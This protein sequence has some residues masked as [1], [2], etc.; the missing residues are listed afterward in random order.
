MS[1]QLA[2][3]D[4][5]VSMIQTVSVAI[6]AGVLLIIVA[7][8]INFPAIVLLLLGGVALGPAVLGEHA[9]VN[10]TA[11]GGGLPVLVSF[12][13]GLILF[14]GGLTLDPEGYRTAPR[15]IKRLLTLGILITWSG[16]STAV[17]LLTDVEPKIAI[18]CGSM[19]IVTGPTVIAPLL[20]RL[21]VN[22][23]L[24]SI[25]HWE[26]VLIDPMG[27]FIAV[28]CFEVVVAGASGQ[29]AA[30]GLGLRIL[31]G[32]G[33]GA[34]GGLALSWCTRRQLIPEDMLNVF[35]VAVAVLTFG[36]A[37]MVRPEAGLLSVTVAGFVFGLTGA[38]RVKQV[39]EFKAELT[40]LLI[41]MLFILLSARLSFDQFSAFGLAGA[42]AVASVMVL[43]RPLAIMACSFGLD[44]TRNERIFLSWVAPRGIVAASLASLF[45]ISIKERYPEIADSA[46]FVETFVFSVIIATIVLQGLTSGPLAR[47]LKLRRTPSTGWMIVGSH[48]FGVRVAEFLR[49]NGI[50]CLLVDTNRRSVREAQKRSL[51]ALAA[52]ARDISLTARPEFHGIGNLLALTDNEDLNIRLCD[53]WSDVFGAEHVVR[54]NPSQR[55]EGEADLDANG[56]I[57]WSR[58]PRPSLLAGELQRGQAS[59][60]SATG[61]SESLRRLAT[62]IATL[63][64]G[65]F[66]PL[67]P[68]DDAVNDEQPMLYL[69]RT[70][71]HL[72]WSIRPRLVLDLDVTEME[73][74]FAR[75]AEAMVSVVPDLNR[76]ETVR[77]LLE[78][79]SAFP[80]VLGHGVA[81]PH[82][83]SSTLSGRI[84][85]IAR[86]RGAGIDFVP[87]SPEPVRLVFCLM[88][89]LGDP[90][91]HLATLAEIARLMLDEEVRR[92]ILDAASPLE[93]IGVIGD[94]AKRT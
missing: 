39:R 87:G 65:Q 29:E 33:F 54:C 41:G 48:H 73:P 81:L 46:V 56:R 19:V 15:M 92:S 8:R 9:I 44:V 2:A 88:S 94:H 5:A 50:R 26:G 82:A 17:W 42:L 68:S 63:N 16:A 32:L 79:E 90:E 66:L 58:L 37:E 38:R 25:L 13:I 11:L 67:A 27:V 91:G 70:A 45:A 80:T 83:Y 52:D 85:A 3:S 34:F 14:E 43:V 75:I 40:D 49:E 23:R 20:K 10:P 53:A 35:A 69:Q 21:Q 55:G 76:E 1:L 4:N 72:L 93:V 30:A 78:R 28:L 64:D 57:I 74:L 60:I 84:C 36:A 22:E 6:S 61:S 7:R 86:I 47:L 18:L 51:D 12:A 77:E 62:P 24:N 59:L 89:P 71:E 31:A